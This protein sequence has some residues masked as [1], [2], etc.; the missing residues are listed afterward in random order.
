MEATFD[1]MELAVSI[2]SADVEFLLEIFVSD[3]V[4]FRLLHKLDKMKAN[5]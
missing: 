1:G 3:S 4:Y 5:V 2:K